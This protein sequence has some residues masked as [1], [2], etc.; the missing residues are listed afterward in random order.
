MGNLI[1]SDKKFNILGYVLFAKHLVVD[2]LILCGLI[3]FDFLFNSLRK[4]VEKEARNRNLDPNDP[5][6]KINL[7]INNVVINKFAFLSVHFLVVFC[8]I[9]DILAMRGVAKVSYNIFGL[10]F[11]FLILIIFNSQKSSGYLYFWIP[12]QA[13]TKTMII[14][15][16]VLVLLD[17]EY[18]IH[19]TVGILFEVGEFCLNFFSSIS[20]TKTYICL[21]AI[22]IVTVL[23]IASHVKRSNTPT[24]GQFQ[25]SD[26]V[27]YQPRYPRHVV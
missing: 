11:D 9:V 16:F 18:L 27:A 19:Y 1:K 4:Q 12:V 7:N 13:V 21:T 6:F 10:F 5:N 24:S 22:F 2:L 20:F 8:I 15:G 17:S 23:Y 3:Y 26:E 25:G 14:Y